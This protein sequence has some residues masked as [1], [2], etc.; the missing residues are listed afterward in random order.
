[1]TQRT[2]SNDRN[3]IRVGGKLLCAIVAVSVALGGCSTVST[4]VAKGAPTRRLAATAVPR[5]RGNLAVDAQV[6]L[7]LAVNGLG[8]D[9]LR[10][11]GKPGENTIVSPISISAALSMTALGARGKTAEE[12]DRVLG[13]GA[14]REAWAARLRGL[15]GQDALRLANSLWLDTEVSFQPGFVDADRDFF[16]AEVHTLDLQDPGATTAVNEWVE[17]AT[18]GRIENMLTGEPDPQTLAY[19]V[20]TAYFLCDW[21]DPFSHED[22]VDEPFTLADGEK[23][24]VPMMHAFGDYEYAETPRLQAIRLPYRDQRFA[25]VIVVPK[26]G[27]TTEDLARSLDADAWW[28]LCDGMTDR[29][30]SIAIP[31]F[32][33]AG[34]AFSLKQALAALGMP[35]AFDIH[36]ADFSGMAEDVYLD[37]VV[38]QVYLRVDE[39]G[40][41]AAAATA[42][43]VGTGMP[44]GESF[45]LRADR[46][47]ILAIIDVH[48]AEALAFLGVISDPR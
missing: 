19:V 46:P 45:E 33:S 47:F 13:D 30:G 22:T 31:R 25:A 7:A 36:A 18:E 44:S 40:T 12:M 8:F 38:H 37:N 11:I 24:E 32:E 48:S 10:E 17:E 4:P 1:M 39:K 14:T 2:P 35:K 21:R 9:L 6:G 43:L 3:R 26:R 29:E 23:A 20:N 15:R 16:G 42:A 34:D 41:E 5:E 27:T 28:E